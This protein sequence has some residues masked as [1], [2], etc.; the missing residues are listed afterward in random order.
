MGHSSCPCEL[1]AVGQPGESSVQAV[2]VPDEVHIMPQRRDDCAAL[3]LTSWRAWRECPPTPAVE[4]VGAL[5]VGP[6][7]TD[8]PSYGLTEHSEG[9]EL[10]ARLA[11]QSMQLP[12]GPLARVRVCRGW[13][14]VGAGVTLQGLPSRSAPRVH[15]DV[16]THGG[17]VGGKLFLHRAQGGA[18][19]FV[20]L[21]SQVRVPSRVH[22][23]VRVD[24]FAARLRYV[25]LDEDLHRSSATRRVRRRLGDRQAQGG[26]E[27]TRGR[28]R[29]G[30]VAGWFIILTC[31]FSPSVRT[32]STRG[33][34][35]DQPGCVG[36]LCGSRARSILPQVT[37]VTCRGSLP[38]EKKR[39]LTH[40]EGPELGP[41][42]ERAQAKRAHLKVALL[43]ERRARGRD[44][45]RMRSPQLARCSR[46]QIHL[47][48]A[49][50]ALSD[51]CR[52][53]PRPKRADDWDTELR[54]RARRASYY[55]SRTK[56]HSFS[57]TVT[58]FMRRFEAARGEAA[59][60]YRQRIKDGVDLSTDGWAAAAPRRA[61]HLNSG[62]MKLMAYTGVAA[63]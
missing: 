18:E 61:L 13:V 5:W 20:G 27:E 8:H 48:M 14:R 41:P 51:R 22:S 46:D 29:R 59:R 19:G 15:L 23:E 42:F 47:R 30:C 40:S 49:A 9:G 34:K 38:P 4:Q 17:G 1:H 6:Q 37:T 31:R 57:L 33:G 35:K 26:R 7:G 58:R 52:A 16:D 63:C 21:D 32:A 55:S 24:R 53:W 11:S 56:E 25:E 44:G 43:A 50:L 10:E 28:C 60:A 3:L 2:R 36:T 45:Q 54:Q 62:L 12:E 39:S